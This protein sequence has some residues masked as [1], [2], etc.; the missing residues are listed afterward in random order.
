MADDFR[1]REVPFRETGD[2]VGGLKVTG[3]EGPQIR[4]LRCTRCKTLEELPDFRGRPEDDVALDHLVMV[5][6]QRHPFH[7]DKDA[8]LLRVNEELWRRRKKELHRK[9]WEDVKQEGGFVPEYYATRDTFKEDAVKCHIQHNRQVPC[10]DWR[11]DRKRLGNP[12]KEGWREGR[13]KVYLCDYCPV[14]TFVEA[15]A[16]EQAGD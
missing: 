1:P 13:V 7:E 16:R 10:I 2:D 11:V 14:R 8:F 3:D 9:I 12:T 4:L 6:Q 15:K 5:H